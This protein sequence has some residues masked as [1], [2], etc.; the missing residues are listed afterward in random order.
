MGLWFDYRF[1]NLEVSVKTS[2]PDQASWFREVSPP[3]TAHEPCRRIRFTGIHGGDW[4]SHIK[5]L[6]QIDPWNPELCYE[7]A[8]NTG[9]NSD[10]VKSSWGAMRDYSK[11]PLLQTLESPQ[12]TSAQRIETLRILAPIDPESGLKLGSA[13]VMEKRPEEAIQAYETAYEKTPDRVAVSNQTRWMIHF[14]K[15]HGKDAKAREVADHNEKVYSKSGLDS[16]LALALQEKDSKRANRIA[17][18]ISERYEDMTYSAIAAWFADGDEK[19]L[20]R[21]FPDGLKEVTLSELETGQ[22]LKGARLENQSTTT[23]TLG[24]RGGDV[25]LAID[26]KRVETFRQY[27]MLMSSTLE[28]RTRII[29]RRGKKLK[30]LDCLLPDRRLYVNM[31]DS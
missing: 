10:S 13:L 31:N 29:Y 6:H 23:T 1:P 26:G 11:R 4:V 12:L 27:V 9:N 7:L 16:A 19:A 20:R 5:A 2:M 8:E 28:P 30:E 15:S 22:S 24:M 18:A 17:E 25:I 3:G 14:Y 21:V